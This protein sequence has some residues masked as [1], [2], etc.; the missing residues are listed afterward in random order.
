[1]IANDLVNPNISDSRVF[2]LGVVFIACLALSFW[3]G[4]AVEGVMHGV[5]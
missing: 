5:W 2:V 1:M 4:C 3:S